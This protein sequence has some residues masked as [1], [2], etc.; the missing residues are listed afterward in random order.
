MVGGKNRGET[1]YNVNKLEKRLGK[2]LD[3]QTNSQECPDLCSATGDEHLELRL[4]NFLLRF[5][6]PA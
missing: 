4:L 5:L 2:L 6:Q 3:Q 1:I